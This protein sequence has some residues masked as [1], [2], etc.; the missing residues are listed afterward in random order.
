[1][2]ERRPNP[3]PPSLR[4]RRRYI[5]YEVI[6]EDKILQEDLTNTIWH[7][8]LNFLGE[9]G[10]SQTNMWIVK[11]SYDENKQ[12]GLIRCSHDTVER[13]RASLALIERIGDIRVIIKVLGISGTINA[14]KIKFF[15]ETKLTEFTS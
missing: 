10:T 4:G 5:A 12:T 8:I 2:E 9:H 6:S 15:G 3:L 11:D 13:V 7:S 1:M 14:A